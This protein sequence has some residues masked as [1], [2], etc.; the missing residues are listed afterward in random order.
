[1]WHPAALWHLRVCWVEDLTWPVTAR[2]EMRTAQCLTWSGSSVS[3]KVIVWCRDMSPMAKSMMAGIRGVIVLPMNH[4]IG[5]MAS[6]VCGCCPGWRVGR[7]TGRC[8]IGIP[9]RWRIVCG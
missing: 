5:L 9:L 7:G 8:R 6:I 1:M 2:Y 3:A 4:G